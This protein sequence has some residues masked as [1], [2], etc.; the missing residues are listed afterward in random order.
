M[1]AR[2]MKAD[3][4]A[5]GQTGI[6]ITGD[7]VPARCRD[8]R[9]HGGRRS[10]MADARQRRRSL[11]PD[12]GAGLALPPVLFRGDH[13]AGPWRP[14]GCAGAVSRA[15]A[16]P[17]ARPAALSDLPSLEDLRD[18]ALH[19]ARRVNPDCRVVIGL[20]DQHRRAERGRRR[21]V[22][23]RD[24]GPHGPALRRS[25]PPRRGTAGRRLVTRGCVTDAPY[26]FPNATSR[27]SASD[28][29]RLVEGRD[30]A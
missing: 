2:G 29:A 12:R 9:F 17:Y 28:D 24:R 14:A 21:G 3:F 26:G 8:R 30:E 4:R 6:L 22:S 10:S 16:D 11:G 13:G 5:T 25:V 23:G 20:R 7:G 19:L 27:R 18:T 1:R 15:D